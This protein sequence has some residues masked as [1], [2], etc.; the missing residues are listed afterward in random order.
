MRELVWRAPEAAR[1]F[2]PE[3]LL[4][5]ARVK[6]VR[7]KQRVVYEESSE[8]EESSSDEDVLVVRRR[9]KPKP[10]PVK[11]AKRKP[12][13]VYESDLDSSSGD[14]RTAPSASKVGVPQQPQ[15]YVY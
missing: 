13:V 14:D 6:K 2:F 7:K 8:Q 12:H 1:R 3:P 9:K 10:K 15:F 4:R 11:K 5:S